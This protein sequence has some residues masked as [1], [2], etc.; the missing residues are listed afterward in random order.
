MRTTSNLS[1]R[2]L[3]YIRR[4]TCNFDPKCVQNPLNHP[5]PPSTCAPKIHP[6]HTF[7]SNSSQL[8]KIRKKKKTNLRRSKTHLLDPDGGGCAKSDSSRKAGTKLEFTRGTVI[9]GRTWK[10]LLI[11]RV[12]SGRSLSNIF[13][14]GNCRQRFRAARSRSAEIRAPVLHV[15][16]QRGKRRK[17]E[18]WR[19]DIGR[20]TYIYIYTR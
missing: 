7:P 16:K 6:F 1:S 2:I 13:L 19:V 10:H 17:R 9:N 20:G 12:L 18:E 11:V 3:D 15:Q 5:R 4:D 8:L 14:G